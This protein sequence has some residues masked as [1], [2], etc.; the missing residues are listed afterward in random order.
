MAKAKTAR[1]NSAAKKISGVKK[2]VNKK[3]STPKKSDKKDSVKSNS[4]M[5][6]YSNLA[7]KR[8]VKEDA[9]ARKKA[10][11]LA[12]LPKNPVA[13]F[14]ARLRPD[15]VFKA[16][17]SREGLFH[18]LKFCA[19]CILI[20]I[21]AIGGLFLYF[22]KDLA[23][24]NPEELAKRVANTVNT[25]LDR[26]GELLWEDK[27]SGDYRLVVD[28]SDIS[29]YMRQATV[30]IEDK[31]FYSHIGIDPRGIAR[32]TYV[33]L[34]GGAVQGGSTLTQQ[35]IK[36]VYFSDEAGDRGIGGIPRKIKEMILAIEIEKM[37]SKEEIIT[38]YLNESPYGGRRNGVESAA[39]TYFGKSAKDLNLS[40]S[41]LLAAIPNNPGVLNPYNIA[42]N[43]A[44]I[45]RQHKVLTS[46]VE[47]GYISQEEA[48]EARR[49]ILLRR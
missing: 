11:E 26:N 39:Q 29:T 14:F 3:L 5:S 33:T 15:R 4:N 19:A 18:I 27:G 44:L 41:A 9:R 38:L 30:A 31:N 17:F 34:T 12:K 43:K 6:L 40:E 37:Y 10:E 28:G 49:S 25:Y 22:K 47:M 23:E 42:G 21:I 13:R 48:D 45:S 24:I 46:M 2:S 1:T 32:A 8:R 7:Y 36:Q 16:I 20:L 35:L